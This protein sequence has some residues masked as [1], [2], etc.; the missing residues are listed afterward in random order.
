METSLSGIE[1]SHSRNLH[2]EAGQVFSNHTVCDTHTFLLTKNPGNLTKLGAKVTVS[3]LGEEY[4]EW[5]RGASIRV[6]FKA[7]IVWGV[8]W[9]A[10]PTSP[11][12]SWNIYTLADQGYFPS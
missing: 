11:P 2:E 10:L 8:T 12:H 6:K 9:V 7:T 5:G 4:G 3:F 1:F